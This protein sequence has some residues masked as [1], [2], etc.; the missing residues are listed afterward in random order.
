M[1]LRK[2]AVMRIISVIIY[3]CCYFKLEC[4]LTTI[5]YCPDPAQRALMK[6]SMGVMDY[7]QQY[8]RRPLSQLH[9]KIF[10]YNL[11]RTFD[12]RHIEIKSF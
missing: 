1:L 6:M 9:S 4:H 2:S 8:S 12:K 10:L 11:W 7:S 3:L 5:I